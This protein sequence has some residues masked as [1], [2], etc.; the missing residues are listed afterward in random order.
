MKTRVV[1]NWK[2]SL[3]GLMLMIV[4]IT[5]LYMKVITGGE[6]IA[7]LPTILGL[8]L[9]PDSLFRRDGRRKTDET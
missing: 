1:R 7:L 2:T 4:S 3:L 6:M 5:L 8:L 9:A